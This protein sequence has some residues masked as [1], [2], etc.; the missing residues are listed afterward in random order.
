M[1]VPHERNVYSI[2]QVAGWSAGCSRTF[3]DVREVDSVLSPLSLQIF[4]LLILT[5]T[6]LQVV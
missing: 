1:N 3:T 4:C 2:L 6:H 5:I